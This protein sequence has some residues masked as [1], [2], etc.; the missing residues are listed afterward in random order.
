MT[1]KVLPFK[2]K[3]PKFKEDTIIEESL[4]GG[5]DGGDGGMTDLIARVQ[6]LEDIT[7]DL[8]VDVADI[9][10]RLPSLAKQEDLVALKTEFHTILP[11]LAT[12]EDVA[13]ASNKTNRWLIG[14]VLALV[15]NIAL[16]Y[17]HKLL[18][19]TDAGVNHSSA[20]QMK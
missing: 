18:S 8:R 14:I 1:F 6:R 15:V 4:S 20:S 3:L 19:Y 12:K 5:N 10:A 9:K 16:P 11:T 2:N 13:N 7:N 17:F